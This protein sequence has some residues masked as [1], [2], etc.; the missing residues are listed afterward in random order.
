MILKS[1]CIG[2]TFKIIAT[3][4]YQLV[5]SSYLEQFYCANIQYE[6]S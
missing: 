1:T 6:I 3:K 5:Q 2:W 4:R